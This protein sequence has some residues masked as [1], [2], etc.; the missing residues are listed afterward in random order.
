MGLDMYLR[1]ERR[2][3]KDTNV[4]KALVGVTG[5]SL[6]EIAAEGDYGVYL[7]GWDFA[8]EAERSAHGA[9]LAAAGLIGF[10]TKDSLGATIALI[11]DAIVA[12]A[13]CIYWRK[14]NAVHDWFVQNA[15]GGVDECQ[16]APV[17]AEQLLHLEA[18]CRKAMACYDA[19]DAAGAHAALAPT[20]GVFF[21]S[22][23]ID[24]WYRAD[25][26][27]TVDEIKRVVELAVKVGG[28]TFS[29]RSSW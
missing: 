13:T 2:W 19:G 15:Q 10:V 22:T 20:S 11:D 17:E 25:L 1:A 14:A 12:Q 8:P 24:E 26:Q 21:G 7:A 29:Y 28:I 3:P 6:E 27:H 5:K 4:A 16:E 9:V 18:Q 23:E